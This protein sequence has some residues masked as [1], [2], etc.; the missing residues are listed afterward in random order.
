MPDAA[1]HRTHRTAILVIACT[2]QFMVVLDL[3][4]VSV[5]LPSMRTGLHMSAVDQQWVVNA[6]TLL[7]GG[8][9]LL[10]G[11]AADLFGRRR[12][13]L[14]GLALF[15][16]ASLA[17]GLAQSSGMLIGAR[18]AQGLGA[19]VLAPATLS[20]L[21]ATFEEGRPRTRALT[22]W[23]TTAATGGS[24]GT[25]LGGI[26]T[27]EISWRW[28]LFV[29]VPI[30]IGVFAL[31]LRFLYVPH[32]EEAKPRLDLP[33]AV[34]ITAG[35]ATLIYAIVSTDKHAWGSLHTVGLLTLG[36]VLVGAFI[37]IEARSKQPLVPMHIFNSRALVGAD[38][39]SF[40]LGGLIIGQVFF[41]AQYLQNSN[42]Y[43][44]EHA[45]LVM[46]VPTLGAMVSSIFAGHIVNRV[47]PRAIL[48]GGPL[49]CAVGS[50]WLS[51]IQAGDSFP[52]H[53][54][55]PVLL[56]IL[57][58]ACCFVPQTMCATAGVRPQEAGLASGLLNSSRQ[59]G[60]ALFLA[61]LAT[62]AL[63]ETKSAGHAGVPA[64]DA[65]AQGYARALLVT[66][67]I[68]IAISIV[69]ATVIPRMLAVPEAAPPEALAVEV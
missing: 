49:L 62:I 44:P 31:A 24:F 42:G 8:F 10:G 65:L 60:S 30:G 4:I 36:L 53:V 20:T 9:L 22:A 64:R 33:G 43:S 52:L 61:I 39:T 23:S 25:A 17:G 46:L 40:L 16:L 28:V 63:S 6:Y 2:V 11:R 14:F 45:G 55:L 50:V 12:V 57:G 29:N 68:A 34:T 56:C 18:A 41:V 37:A 51:R 1:P 19:A 3:T 7:F 27:S 59:I 58:T 13:F 66:G 32:D 48:V 67:F 54:G 5:A 26:L 69:A 15:V 47:G 38:I 21:V 35:I